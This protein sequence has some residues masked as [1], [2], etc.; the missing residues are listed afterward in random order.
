MGKLI[1]EKTVDTL[2]SAGFS[3]ERGFPAG[4]IPTVTEPVCAVNL[5][6]ANLR[7]QTATVLVTVLSPMELG[8]SACE[9]AALEAARILS[10]MGGKCTVNA[11]T[12]QEKV[13]L[14]SSEVTAQFFTSVPKV[15]LGGQALQSVTAFTCWRT[16]DEEI[17]N[18][19]DAPWCFRLE[20][21]FPLG[22]EEELEPEEPFL[23]LHISEHGSKTFSNCTWTYQ[24]RVWSADGTR[25]IRLGQAESMQDG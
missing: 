1:L 16:V 3:V 12:A 9:E 8:A 21:F 7:Q 10:E 15:V 20:E 19:D 23:L 13:D 17:T 22:V 6:Q 24:R 2:R 11:C 5:K 25:Q 14:F 4:A 18:L